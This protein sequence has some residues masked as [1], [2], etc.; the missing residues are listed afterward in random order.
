MVNN[1]GHDETGVNC[2]Q[3]TV[4][5][6]TLAVRPVRY[7]E[8]NIIENPLVHNRTRKFFLATRPQFLHRVFVAIKKRLLFKFAWT[9]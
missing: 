7:F 2:E 9:F 8:K 1:I 5:S 6:T 4:F 3:S